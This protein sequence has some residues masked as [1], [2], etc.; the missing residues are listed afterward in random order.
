M[1]GVQYSDFVE[2]FNCL[3]TSESNMLV[4]MTVRTVLKV[5]FGKAAPPPCPSDVPAPLHEAAAYYLPKKSS[6]LRFFFF[7]TL[8]NAQQVLSV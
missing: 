6:F 2:V 5:P 8:A 4:V 1:R 3:T 7:K